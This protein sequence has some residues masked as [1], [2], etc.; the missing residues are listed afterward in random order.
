MFLLILEFYIFRFLSHRSRLAAKFSCQRI[1]CI[2]IIKCLLAYFWL[3]YFWIS[4][5]DINNNKCNNNKIICILQHFNVL[6]FKTIIFGKFQLFMFVYF[7]LRPGTELKKKT[8][9]GV[10]T[11]RICYLLKHNRNNTLNTAG[12]SKTTT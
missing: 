10:S 2:T 3:K 7:G 1:S 6:Y 8:G 11:T 5:T 4:T 9:L 12:M